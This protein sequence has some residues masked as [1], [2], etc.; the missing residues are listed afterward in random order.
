MGGVTV[1]VS[2]WRSLEGLRSISIIHYIY[3]IWTEKR[4]N[5]NPKRTLG[6]T[7]RRKG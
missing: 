3:K 2:M 5:R 1:C 6:H 4:G 7:L